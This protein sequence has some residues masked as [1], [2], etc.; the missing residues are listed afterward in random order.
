MKYIIIKTATF[1]LLVVATLNVNAQETVA[2]NLETILKLSDANNLTIKEFKERQV[3][4]EAS[5]SKAKEWWLPEIN[6]GVQTQNYWGAVQN[7]NGNFFL[8]V[9]KNNLWAGLGLNANWKIADGIFNTQSAKLKLKASEYQTQ[10]ERNKSI[11]KSV[12]LYYDLL[13]AQVKWQAYENLAKQSD[14][15]A[16]QIAIQVE[17]GLRHQ[18]ELLLAKSNHSHLK[19]EMLNAK[20]QYNT[21]SSQLVKELNLKP[22][23]KVV[24]TD[25][26]LIPL[27]FNDA[28]IVQNDINIS[29]RPELKVIDYTIESL[30][31]EKKKYTIGLLI[32]EFN[33]GTYGSYFGNQNGSVMPMLPAQYPETKQLYPTGA[34]NLSLMWRIPLGNLVFGG[35]KKKYNSLLNLQ[36]IKKQQFTAQANQEVQNA[37][38]QIQL[39]KE[40]II[41]TK[42]AV[43]LTAEALSQSIARQQLGTVKPFEVFQAQQFYLQAQVDYLKAVSEYNKAQFGLKVAKGEKL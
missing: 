41:L 1:I 34:L 17:A 42:E 30:Q 31:Q 10:A 35:D 40:Q 24:A 16:Q 36:E 38:Q 9:N 4:S 37:N 23:T 21:F 11:L 26:L 19:A 14:T 8:D 7:G 28:E 5:L 29:N 27:N 43:E 12:E 20:M 2:L 22:N 6:A 13:S 33:V 39:G 3:L 32:P 25:S 18:S 15:L